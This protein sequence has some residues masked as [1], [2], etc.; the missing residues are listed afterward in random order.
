MDGRTI[1]SNW[2][3]MAI[4]LAGPFA[5]GA[6]LGFP[7]GPSRMISEGLLLPAVVFG[8]TA[9]MAPALYIGMSLVGASPPATEVVRAFG[10]GLRACGIVLAGLAPAT[11]FLLA[12]ADG[13]WA[14]WVF[15]I[16]AVGA[17]ALLG[18]RRLFNQ[19]RAE[20]T[21]LLRSLPLYTVWALVS[22]G[23][24]VHFF[25]QTLRA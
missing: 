14:V 7:S 1:N 9:L 17:A 10:D 16:A 3:G 8:V 22:L 15:G 19:L 2:S 12:T 4:A 18:V 24:G 6:V 21:S 23:L 25:V 11:A 20:D 5:M 13:S